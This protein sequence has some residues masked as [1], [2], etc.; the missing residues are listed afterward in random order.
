MAE[1]T[2]T[3]EATGRRKGSTARVR[4]TP[5]TGRAFINGREAAEFVRRDAL[6]MYMYQPLVLTETDD[7][8]DMQVTV[9][10]GGLTGST[11]AIRHG[12]SRAL[13][14]YN[15]EFRT[16]LKRAGMLTRDSRVKERKKYGLKGARA[17]FQFSKR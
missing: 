9:S 2:Q 12:I 7:K 4:L 8:L 16:P 3:W 15:P 13:L 5:G 6:L 14:D 1:K 10:G 17:R 11:G